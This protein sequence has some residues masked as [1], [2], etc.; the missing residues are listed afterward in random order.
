[1]AM[2]E[3]GVQHANDA[4]MVGLDQAKLA[5][6]IRN[7]EK[8]GQEMFSIYISHIEP[9]AKLAVR[10]FFK[11]LFARM[12]DSETFQFFEGKVGTELTLTAE[13]VADLDMNVTL[14]MTRYRGEQQLQSNLQAA[15]H[16]TQ[17]FSFPPEIQVR[18]APFYIQ[19]LKAL[20]IQDADEIIVPVTAMIVPP[21]GTAA[22]GAMPAPPPAPNL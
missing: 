12:D 16:V 11:L 6:G 18:V 22:Q 14:E 3:S 13:E 1:M 2:N 9:G 17:F 4:Q 19:I 20:Q 8:S 21:P 10:K 5:T 7:I 15:T